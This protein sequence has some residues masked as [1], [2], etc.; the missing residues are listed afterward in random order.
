MKKTNEE[1][2]G[3]ILIDDEN[4]YLLVQLLA[5]HWDFPKGHVEQGETE[6]ETALREVLEETGLQATIF[7]DFRERVTYLV[8]GYIPKEVVYFLGRPHSTDVKIQVE[9]VSDFAFLPYEAA[10]KRLT[11]ETN[12]KLLDKAQAFVESLNENE[13]SCFPEL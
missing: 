4:H 5:G 13:M 12:R 3:S 6:K 11:F 2:C 1:S 7:P 10:R 8:K 9:E